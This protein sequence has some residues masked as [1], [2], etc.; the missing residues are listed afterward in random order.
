MSILRVLCLTL[1]CLPFATSPNFTWAQRS[2]VSP[3]LPSSRLLNRYGLQRNWWSHATL[4]PKRDKVRHLVIDEENLYVQASSGVVSAFNNESGRRLWAIQL[5][6]QDGPSYPLVSNEEFALIVVGLN[7][8]AVNKST[9]ELIWEISL[10]TQPSTSPGVD[11]LRVYIGSLDGSVYAYDLQKIHDLYDEN[12]LPQSSREALVWRYKTARTITTPPISTGLVVNFAS[13]DHSLYSVTAERREQK[14]QF[15]TDAPVSAPI[16]ESDGFLYMASED[17]NLYCLNS[18]NGVLRW[19]PFISGLPIR[20]TP[21]IVNAHVFLS[22]DRGGLYCLSANTG[23]SIWWQPKGTEFL[24]ATPER[25]FMSDRLGNVVI[26][27]RADGT[28]LGALPLRNFS[29]RLVNDRTDRLY[30]VTSSGLI[31]CIREQDREFPLYHK[32]PDHRPIMPLFAPEA[33]SESP[34]VPPEQ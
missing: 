17:F 32:F 33:D 5:G 22:P 3:T 6:Q 14:F 34:P 7:L 18:N 4:N 16:A 1:C 21:V 25:V 30:L 26:L 11:N 8:Y 28:S 29:H 27:D 20:K 13:Q 23:K 10:P 19:D 24:A 15:Q 31:V 12:R 9:G 2:Q